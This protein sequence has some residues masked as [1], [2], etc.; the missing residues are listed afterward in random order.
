MAGGMRGIIV[1]PLL[2]A[3]CI[4]AGCSRQDAAWQEA[5]RQNT[6]AAYQAYLDR[7]PGG[8]HAADARAGIVTAREA[9]AWARA[10]R[11]KTPEAWQ[12]YLAEWPDGAHA[13][14][15]RRSLTEFIPPAAPAPGKFEIQLGAWS[16]EASAR[17]ALAGWS[18][19]QA[20]LGG[21]VARIDGPKPG[22]APVWRL[23][24][25][26]Y[27]EAAARVVCEDLKSA[28]VDCVA[29]AAGSA[30]DAPP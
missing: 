24:S 6:P 7:Y 2:I 25:G 12:R 30:G 3:A 29:V 9:A 23:R 14:I 20:D 10:E 27:D 18:G 5:A 26:P 15:A 19:R 22:A 4:A 11:L 1:A 21:Q 28:G 17:A 13:P 8:A 16:D